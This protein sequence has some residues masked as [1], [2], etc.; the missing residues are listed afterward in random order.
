[1]LR[2]NVPGDLPT[3][4]RFLCALMGSPDGRQIDGL[5][6]ADPLTSKVVLVNR[7]SH[8]GVDIDY[9]SI[10]V[11]I[12]TATTNRA[13]T[14]GN[15]ISGA[16]HF[17]AAEGLL[18]LSNPETRVMVR[19]VN[20]NKLIELEMST[21][22]GQPLFTGNVQIAGVPG[23]GAA[24]TLRYIDPI[25]SRFPM[26]TPLGVQHRLKL[27]NVELPLSVVDA[28]AL[29]A[30]VPMTALRVDPS[31]KPD[32][33]DRDAE[34]RQTIEDIRAATLTELNA[35]GT[36]NAHLGPAAQ[37]VA[38]VGR[39]TVANAQI[40]AIVVNRE[41]THKTISMGGCIALSIAAATPGTVVNECLAGAVADSLVVEHP[42]GTVEAASGIRAG[43]PPVRYVQLTRTARVIMRG[44]ATVPF[45]E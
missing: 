33:L 39:P 2:E 23:S 12:T 9:E 24:V 27:R 36:S 32:E 37:K 41:R 11:A 38:L 43:S 13:I 3:Q 20:T 10:E 34:L 21:P 29:Y 45:F 18:Q 42:Q 6:G 25:G 14:C 5:G 28:G 1:M 16:G 40:K 7:S 17:A 30:F 31:I 26:A 22:R 4:D 15:L 19:S 8:P 44:I 35:L